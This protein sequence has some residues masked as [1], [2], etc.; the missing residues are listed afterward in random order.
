MTTILHVAD[1][2]LE[3][4]G[5]MPTMKLQKLVFYSQAHSLS[6]FGTP[7]FDDDFQAWT[8]GP[9]SMTLFRCHRKKFL[10]RPTELDAYIDGPSTLTA[11]E[12]MLI[13]Q[14]CREL[15]DK[16]GNQLS[17]RTH[18]ESPWQEARGD[19]PLGDPCSSIISKEAI[20]EYYSHHPVCA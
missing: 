7:L 1:Y 18:S 4:V 15:G 6:K 9:V 8:G 11:Q 2:V 20:Q 13:Q 17:Q 5:T 16:T 12:K 10:I 19:I 3:T 14:V